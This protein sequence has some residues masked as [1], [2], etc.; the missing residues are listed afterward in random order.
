MFK[1]KIVFE[2]LKD[3]HRQTLLVFTHDVLS[4]LKTKNGNT[5]YYE[6]E[7][8]RLFQEKVL[9]VLVSSNGLEYTHASSQTPKDF[10]ITFQNSV[11][12]LELKKTNGTVI[13][14]NDTFPS[15]PNTYYIVFTTNETK[16]FDPQV[17]FLSKY[18][19]HNVSDDEMR[20]LD[21]K[22]T[23]LRIMAQTLFKNS[24]MYSYPR[25]NY[26]FKISSFLQIKQKYHF[27]SLIKEIK[28]QYK[29]KS[30]KLFLHLA[31]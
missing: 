11:F 16:K 2:P 22:R 31:T 12:H 19:M 28:R 13:M 5:Q 27:N 21:D 20:L 14:L 3:I 23:E 6:R 4:G 15:D 29:S 9:D 7:Y 18:N 25:P 26:S 17:L 10:T 24:N 1:Q 30:N 8:T